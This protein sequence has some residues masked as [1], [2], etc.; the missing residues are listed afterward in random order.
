[1]LQKESGRQIRLG[2]MRDALVENMAVCSF[3]SSAALASYNIDMDDIVLHSQDFDYGEVNGVFDTATEEQ[4]MMS[5]PSVP[6]GF[7]SSATFD[8]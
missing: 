4:H 6:R 8:S 5:V 2:L 7:R 3:C 1:M